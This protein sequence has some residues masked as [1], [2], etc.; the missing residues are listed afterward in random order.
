MKKKN[1]SQNQVVGLWNS[2]RDFTIAKKVPTDVSCWGFHSRYSSTQIIFRSDLSIEGALRCFG[3]LLM[4]LRF[5]VG[6]F[7]ELGGVF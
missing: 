3:W 1:K 7:G 6:W 4:D 2:L 5:E